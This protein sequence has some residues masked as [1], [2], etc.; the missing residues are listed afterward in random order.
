MKRK[1]DYG[2]ILITLFTIIFTIVIY[3]K[4]P[5]NIDSEMDKL[6]L[7]FIG[8]GMMLIVTLYAQFAHKISKKEWDDPRT[9]TIRRQLTFTTAIIGVLVMYKSLSSINKIAISDKTFE[10]LISSILIIVVGNSF[11][12]ISNNRNIG[13]RVPWTRADNEIWDKTHK[14]SGY[15]SLPF[16]ISIPI[17][18][19]LFGTATAVVVGILGWIII[20]IGYSMILYYKKFGT[21]L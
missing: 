14:L 10:V 8:I 15:L 21:L 18:Y 17:L 4:L 20:S 6:G 5:E 11:T 3:S 1:F 2:T 7:F 13:I 12:K 19:L 9:K 16:G